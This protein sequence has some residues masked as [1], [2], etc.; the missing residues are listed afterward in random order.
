MGVLKNITDEYFGDNIRKEDLIEISDLAVD[1]VKFTDKNGTF[2]GC[3]Y[4]VNKG[5]YRKMLCTLKVLIKRMIERR[6]RECDLNDI[7]VSNMVCLGYEYVGLFEHYDFDGD[8]TGWDVSNV[9]SMECMFRYSKFTGKKGIFKI[10]RGYDIENM[11]CM[12]E[13]SVFNGNISDW[14]T[15]NVENMDNMFR[16]SIFE[17]DI[18]GWIVNEECSLSNT[19]RDSFLEKNGMLPQWYLDRMKKK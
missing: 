19:F 8:I 12:F 18:N 9:T 16:D 3:G 10:E 6:G 5:K 7:D 2:H 4:R 1:I 15:V 11:R 13:N 17:G 14:H